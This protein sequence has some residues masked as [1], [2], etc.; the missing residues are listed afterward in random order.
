[1]SD[2]TDGT[3]EQHVA[4]AAVRGTHETPLDAGLWALTFAYVLSQFFRSYVAVIA[5]QLIADF[6]FSPQMFGWFA[7]AF[8]L[9]FALAQLPVGLMFDR[10]GVRGPTVALMIVG[11]FCA[12]VLPA[13][14]RAP[15]ALIAQAG[16]GLGCAPIFMGLLNHVLRTGHG[17]RN[18]RA[19]TT[20]SAIGMAGALLAALPLSRATASFGWR[21]V[22]AVAALAMLVAALGVARFVKPRDALDRSRERRAAHDTKP[23][24]QR[25]PGSHAATKRRAGLWTLMP[26]CL[27]MSVGSTFRTSWGGP[28]LADVFGFDVI[29]RGNAMTVT[30]VVGIVASFG[31]PLAVRFLS[32]KRIVLAWLIAGMLAALALACVPAGSAAVSV[33][34]ICILFSVG[35]IHPLVMSQARSIIAP[36]R[37]GLGLGLLNSLV[38]LGIALASSCFGWI[39]G[40]A[41]ASGL[42]SAASYAWLFAVTVL[43]L[44]AGAAVYFFSPAMTAAADRDTART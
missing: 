6:H 35:S 9:V 29:A 31:I 5:P 15:L 36:H 41:K 30:S 8:F 21:V 37:L 22:I 26:A 42:T 14:T 27:A 12:A 28:Y 4:H 11:A 43:P 17:A 2:G 25:T 39:A 32:P 40:V 13:T 34:L 23:A 20:A 1:M 3:Q 33:A 44:A 10:Y 38:F 19:V 7:G 24:T 18:V 16:I